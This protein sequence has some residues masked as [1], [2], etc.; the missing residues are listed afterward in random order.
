MLFIIAPLE[1]PPEDV[2][3]R[4]HYTCILSKVV[5]SGVSVSAD[6]GLG[7]VLPELGMILLGDSTEEV[8]AD[9]TNPCHYCGGDPAEAQDSGRDGAETGDVQ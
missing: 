1:R 3:L 7:D 9:L 4:A 6:A 5:E 2:W 8:W